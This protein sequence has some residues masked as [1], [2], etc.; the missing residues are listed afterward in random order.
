MARIGIVGLGNWGTALAKVW[1][2]TG[3]SVMGWTIEEEVYASITSTGIN[4]KIPS[5]GSP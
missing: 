5:W 4:E 1:G 3:H 2:G